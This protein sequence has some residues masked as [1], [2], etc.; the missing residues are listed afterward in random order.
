MLN[1][2]EFCLT[3]SASPEAQYTVVMSSK[4]CAI[5]RF[6]GLE[7]FLSA[8]KARR[9]PFPSLSFARSAE[10]WHAFRR[11]VTPYLFVE[12]GASVSQGWATVHEDPADFKR[13]RY[14]AV[15]VCVVGPNRALVYDCYGARADDWP[16]LR[17]YGKKFRYVVADRS[18]G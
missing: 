17:Q 10:A 6:D 4:G 12:G 11:D 8:C 5:V 9:L 15:L 14:G 2:E 7:A 13:D 16:G 18:K 1:F 3:E